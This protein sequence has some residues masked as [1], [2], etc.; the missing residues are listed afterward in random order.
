[1]T[2]IP[3]PMRITIPP[4]KR[5]TCLAGEFRFTSP[6]GHQMTAEFYVHTVAIDKTLTYDGIARSLRDSDVNQQYVICHK[7]L[8]E[9]GCTGITYQRIKEFF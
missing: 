5:E 9:S 6:D 2:Y 7:Q 4:R 3:K 1:M 8:L